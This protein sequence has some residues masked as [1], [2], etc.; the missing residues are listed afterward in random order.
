MPAA[1]YTVW[2]GPSTPTAVVPAKAANA[3]DTAPL[4]DTCRIFPSNCAAT[5]AQPEAATQMP[6]RLFMTAPTPTPGAKGPQAPPP[7]ARVVTAAV[8]ER[9]RTLQPLY[10]DTKAHAKVGEAGLV[11][12]ARPLG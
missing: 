6:A 9:R 3:S 11:S 5:R 1:M 2:E 8:G 12:K 4:G 7:P 10:S